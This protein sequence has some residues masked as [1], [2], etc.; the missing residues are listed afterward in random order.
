[1]ITIDFETRSYAD[2]KK[3]GAWV[4]SEDPT[5]DIICVCY[6]IEDRAIKSWWPHCDYD[7]DQQWPE[8]ALS[9]FV[10]MPFDLYDALASG[11]PV[12]AHNVAFEK[13][14][15]M[16]VLAPAYGWIVPDHM[17]WRDTMAVAAYYSLP[18]ALDK[19]CRVLG[20]EGKDPEGGRLISKY[21]KLH[22]KTAKPEIPDEDFFKFVEYCKQD[23]EQEQDVSDFLGELPDEELEIFLVDQQINMRGLY[24][25]QQS[26][27]DALVIVEG[28]AKRLSEE[29]RKITGVNPGQHDKAKAWFQA[30]ECPVENLQA[31]YIEEVLDGKHDF[32]PAG[33]AR[34]ALE[35]RK[36]FNK[37]STKKLAAMA[38]NR[39]RDGR[40]RFQT[41]YHG[42]GTGRSA[43]AGFQP[44][45]MSRGFEHIPPARL[46]KDLSFRNPRYLRAVY[47]DCMEAV[48][49]AT[50]HHIRAEQ[51]KRLIA[52]D[53]VSVEAV[54]LA[55]LAGESWKIEAFRNKDPVY[56][57][58]A[59][60]IHKLGPEAIALAREDK[61]SFK[62]Q[63]P[64]ERFDGKTGE[65]AFGFQG[66]LG[67]WRKFDSS[68]RHE[69]EAIIQICKTWRESNPNIVQFWRDLDDASIRCVRH[70][71]ITHAGP[72]EFECIG[73]W[74]SMRLPNG[75][76]IWYWDPQL[77]L[78]MP[79]WH[80]PGVKESC[81]NGTCRCEPRR[82]LTYMSQKDGQWK[83]VYTY[84]G[85][86][87]ENATQATAREILVAALRKVNRAGYLIILSV[88]DEIVAEVTNGFGSTE[89]FAELMLESPGQWAYYDGKPWPISVDVWEGPVYKK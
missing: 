40:A 60:Q 28:E 11:M 79:A 30:H 8:H 33:E 10:P 55:C 69:D 62:A 19:L 50:R 12:E 67:A 86:L 71:E 7:E 64:D 26:I 27:D 25:N 24:L 2:L 23:V 16:N 83:R 53:F 88:Y 4:Y 32:A 48:G 65:L 63:Y 66:A 85:K 58:M 15:W 52:G 6:G 73:N 49:K 72:I 43:G 14:I 3:V 13:S 35:V 47:G 42:T 22:L 39:G 17:Q 18:Q 36:E 57:L 5:T 75:K 46:L 59:C 74:L 70:K 41:R 31:K 45:N 29:F 77:R 20:F 54:V 82:Q 76:R 51:G 80:K 44:L 34:R 37:A 61:E 38:R 1:M 84:G 81:T 87:C 89:D 21:S 56:E 78:A 68:D 9:D